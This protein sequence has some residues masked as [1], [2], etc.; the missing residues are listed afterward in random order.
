MCKW[1]RLLFVCVLALAIPVQGMAV[2]TMVTCGLKTSKGNQAVAV[3]VAAAPTMRADCPQHRLQ[4]MTQTVLRTLPQAVADTSPF[5]A[6]ADHSCS[7]CAA[8]CAVGAIIP[9]WPVLA[10]PE[11]AASTF[12][13]D[14]ATID[15]FA[16]DGPDR[17][18][19][20]VMT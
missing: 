8:C 2:A 9:T 3:A 14:V 6:S 19:R 11:L 4:P 17:P 18:P 15:A 13:V 7:A 1:L 10:A 20:R 5:D 16:S 12:C